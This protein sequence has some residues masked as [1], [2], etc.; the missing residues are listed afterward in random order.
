MMAATIKASLITS[1]T[2]LKQEIIFCQIFEWYPFIPL[3]LI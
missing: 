3:Y 1:S 2:Q